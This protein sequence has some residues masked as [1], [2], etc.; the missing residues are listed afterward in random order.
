MQEKRDIKIGCFLLQSSFIFF[1][2]KLKLTEI[3][4]MII[5]SE[6]KLSYY[7]Y[8]VRLF[9]SQSRKNSVTL[10]GLKL[11]MNRMKYSVKNITSRGRPRYREAAWRAGVILSCMLMWHPCIFENWERNEG[12]EY[13]ARKEFKQYRYICLPYMLAIKVCS[14]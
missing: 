9:P 12:I 14:H 5:T 13:T 8:F 1:W 6:L 4:S 2:E 11:L 3:W 7:S 10:I